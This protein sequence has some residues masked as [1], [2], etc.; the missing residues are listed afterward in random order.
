MKGEGTM[1]N[2]DYRSEKITNDNFIQADKMDEIR[3]L[4]HRFNLATKIAKICECKDSAVEKI[5]DVLEK[6][7]I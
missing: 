7:G 2:V 5:A 4:E 3:T 6:A 1:K